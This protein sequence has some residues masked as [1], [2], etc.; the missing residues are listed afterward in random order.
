MRNRLF[1]AAFARSITA[2][3]AL[4]DDALPG[5]GV[6]IRPS[7]TPGPLIALERRVERSPVAVSTA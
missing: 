2:E 7:R 1:L 3:V 5:T 4:V 6:T